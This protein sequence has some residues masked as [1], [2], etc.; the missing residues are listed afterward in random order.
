MK[1]RY[2]AP[3]PADIDVLLAHVHVVTQVLMHSNSHGALSVGRYVMWW[4]VN[5]RSTLTSK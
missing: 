5:L 2:Q 4:L 1:L 3:Q